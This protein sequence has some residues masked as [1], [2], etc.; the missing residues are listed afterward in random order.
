MEP[1]ETLPEQTSQVPKRTT[2]T[3]EMELLLSGATVFALWQIASAMA[4]FAYYLVPRLDRQLGQI[5]AVLYIY[6]ASGVI[7]IGLAFVI[8]LIL[9]A[10]WVALV[11]MHSVFPGGLKLDR[12]KGGP[13]MRESLLARWQ[14]L[15]A[16][17]ERAD[18]RATIVFGLGIGVA[19]VLIPVTL[20]VV[21]VYALAAVTCSLLGRPELTSPAFFALSAIAF[22]PFL[23]VQLFDRWWGAR[24]VPGGFGYRL[25]SRI[26]AVYSRVGMGREANPLVTLYTSNVGEGRGSIVVMV[27]MI[28]TVLI[29]AGTF[30]GQRMELGPGSY[31]NYPEP[32]RG[33]PATLDGRHYASMHE[34]G[35]NIRLPY[36][37]D[38]VVR[39]NY[40]KLVVP[41]MPMRDSQHLEKCV[42]DIAANEPEA[43]G[44]EADA[45][46]EIITE[47][48]HR[49][50]LL[51]C[52]GKL[53]VLQLDGGTLSVR[54]DWYTD[55]RR[56]V[57]GLIFMVPVGDLA[58][59]RHELELTVPDPRR[60]G[61]EEDAPLPDKL[62]F[63]R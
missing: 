55:P 36:L 48:A 7:M 14:D 16:A 11:G 41:F 47:A 44:D 30:L 61:S 15:D 13:V 51:A 62:P 60:P 54:P 12:L 25:C 59:G 39:G 4:P 19:S 37:P 21:S 5:G 53:H 58:P 28:V 31:G 1:Q 20:G 29:A 34:P 26:F 22:L 3:W 33:M 56:D 8:H 27:V 52:Y 9:R 10:Y 42:D 45:V 17:I 23:A 38:P 24:L 43:S 50:S 2:P 6:L 46:P 63:W 35:D 32:W 57:R 18:N 40:L 49:Q